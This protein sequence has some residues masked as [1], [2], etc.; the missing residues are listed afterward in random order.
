VTV[1]SHALILGCGYL[2]CRLARRLSERGI[3]VTGTTRGSGSAPAVT[4]AGAR[5]AVWDAAAEDAA[6]RL[7]DLL[8]PAGW[9]FS[10]VAPGRGGAYEAVYL[11][12]AR[13]LVSAARDRGLRVIAVSSTSVYGV[14][15]GSWV[16]ESTPAEPATANGRVLWTMEETLRAGLED[17]V[18]VRAAG[19]YG[20]GRTPAGRLGGGAFAGTGAEWVNLIQIDDLARVLEA[21]AAG[22]SGGDLVLAAD[23]VPV[24]RR[25]YYAEAARLAGAPAPEFTGG[26]LDGAHVRGAGKRIRGR[27]AGEL[28]VTLQYPDYRA[29]L[30]HALG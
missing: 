3:A 30:R 1:A 13:H 19:I 20:P 4:G 9:I 17:V 10:A 12:T 6:D 15:D 18:I 11:S 23:G 14:T 26:A 22:A 24:T 25:D 7:R 16:D 27:R 28:G 5:H 29:G 2:G 8:P 21:A